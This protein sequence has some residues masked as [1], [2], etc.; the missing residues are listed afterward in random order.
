MTPPIHRRCRFFSLALAVSIMGSLAASR[1]VAT[2]IS[3][4]TWSGTRNITGDS[5][6]VNTGALVYAYNFT[7]VDS[8]TTGP[9]NGVVF[10]PFGV[11]FDSQTVTVGSVTRAAAS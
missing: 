1:A 10:Q 4:I 8:L 5:D 6:V 9:V 2:P 11:P 3:P 7:F